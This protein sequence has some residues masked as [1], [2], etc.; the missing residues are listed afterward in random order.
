MI[1]NIKIDAQIFF[2]FSSPPLQLWLSGYLQ[3][4]KTIG[5]LKVCWAI[6]QCCRTRAARGAKLLNWNRLFWLGFGFCSASY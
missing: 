5:H 4:N 1:S 3:K 2:S 6:W